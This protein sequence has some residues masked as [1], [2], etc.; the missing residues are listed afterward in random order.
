MSTPNEEIPEK[1]L[2]F[3]EERGYPPIG[4]TVFTDT[5]IVFTPTGDKSVD[6]KIIQ[7]IYEERKLYTE[8]EVERLSPEF[9]A[10]IQRCVAIASTPPRPETFSSFIEPYVLQIKAGITNNYRVRTETVCYIQCKMTGDKSVDDETIAQLLKERDSWKKRPDSSL[11]N[12]IWSS[13]FLS[14]IRNIAEIILS[15]Q[16]SLLYPK[17]K[18]NKIK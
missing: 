7:K 2:I 8:R 10:L 17:K 14:A 6:D 11:E 16:P 15:L 9:V 13:E 18:I 5:A 12:S 4:I 1:A 3:R